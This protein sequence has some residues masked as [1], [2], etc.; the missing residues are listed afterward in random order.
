[1]A[2]KA[3]KKSAKKKSAKKPSCKTITVCGKKR[4]YCWGKKGI[5]KGYPK[6]VSRKGSR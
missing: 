1:M 4:E 3:A 5:K 6:M 2:K